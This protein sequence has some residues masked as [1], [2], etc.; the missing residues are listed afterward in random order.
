MEYVQKGD[1]IFRRSLHTYIHISLITA[2]NEI[3]RLNKRRAFTNVKSI[4]FL[5]IDITLRKTENMV[6][7]HK[8][9]SIKLK[10]TSK[11]NVRQ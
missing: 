4:S 3:T 9:I 11:H 8:Y 5:S 2:R 10:V 1:F 7:R 6:R